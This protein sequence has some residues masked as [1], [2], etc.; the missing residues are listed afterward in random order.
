MGS[1]RQM[2][3]R[4]QIFSKQ[5]SIQDR[6]DAYV[7]LLS[8]K[9]LY[10]HTDSQFVAK[11]NPAFLTTTGNIHEGLG[12]AVESRWTSSTHPKHGRLLSK[13]TLALVGNGRWANRQTQERWPV[14]WSSRFGGLCMFSCAGLFRVEFEAPQ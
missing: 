2:L 13:F 4:C 5:S 7:P 12:G 11:M 8:S 1:C 9:D 3:M 10:L 14:L 6:L